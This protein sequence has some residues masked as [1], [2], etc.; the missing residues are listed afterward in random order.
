MGTEG[1][2]PR[3]DRG[4][5]GGVQPQAK[6]QQGPPAVAEA[7]RGARTLPGASGGDAALPAPC[8]APRSSR[9]GGSAVRWLHVSPLVLPHGGGRGKSAR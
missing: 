3:D 6:E 4:R 1:R 2:G 9:A 5:D 8:S 7:V